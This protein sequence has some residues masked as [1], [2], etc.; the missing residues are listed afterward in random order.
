LHLN[1]GACN[2][3]Q[4][5]KGGRQTKKPKDKAMQKDTTARSNATLRRYPA[6]QCGGS[7][8]GFASDKE[9]NL[10]MNKKEEERIICNSKKGRKEK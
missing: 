1:E 10:R 8:S 3:K 9:L 5:T 4:Q 7:R 6:S 2:G